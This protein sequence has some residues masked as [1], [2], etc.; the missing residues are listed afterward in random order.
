MTRLPWPESYLVRFAHSRETDI[1]FALAA[2]AIGRAVFNRLG[3]T[4]AQVI[5]GDHHGQ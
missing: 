3:L 4:S 1:G 5:H 2:Q